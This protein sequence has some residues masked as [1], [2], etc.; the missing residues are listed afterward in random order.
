MGF[1]ADLDG[2][3]QTAN[4]HLVDAQRPVVAFALFVVKNEF[5]RGCH[6]GFRDRIG[7]DGSQHGPE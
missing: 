4:P 7:F 6:M 3:T 1:I 5:G 2:E